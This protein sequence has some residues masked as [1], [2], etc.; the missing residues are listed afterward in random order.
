MYQEA[1]H[2]C[3]SVFVRSTGTINNHIHIYVSTVPA[4]VITGAYF[5]VIPQEGFT[6][7]VFAE[8]IDVQKS[9]IATFMLKRCLTGKNY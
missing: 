8:L 6:D 4:I 5:L 1:D 9:L 3:L 7:T 2:V